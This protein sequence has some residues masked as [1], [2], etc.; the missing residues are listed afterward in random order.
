MCQE[1]T[2][3]GRDGP[4]AKKKCLHR[5]TSSQ[6]EILEGFFSLCAH[7][8]EKQRKKLTETTGLTDNQVKFWFQNKRTHVKHLSGKEENYQLKVENEI[9]RAENN[10]L[11]QAKRTIF[12]PRCPSEPGQLQIFQELQRLKSQNEW[13]QQEVSR[14]NSE[15]AMSSSSLSRAS[16]LEFSSENVFVMQDDAQIRAEIARNAVHELV[17]LASTDGPLWLP[18]PGGSMETLNRIA[19]I[20]AFPGQSSA[21]GLKVEATRAYAVVMLDSNNIVEYL[22]NAESYGTFFP[23]IMPGAT[24]TKVYNWPSSCDAGYDGAL[25]M[26]T[27]ELVFPSPLVPARKCTFLRYCQKLEHGATA[28]VDISV[29]NGEGNFNECRKM[30]SGILIEP[31]RTNTCK[32]TAIEHV[33]LEGPDVHDLFK[34]CLSGLLFGA[35]RWVT[36]MARQS[37]RMRDVYHVTNSSMIVSTKGRRIIMKMA[38]ALLANYAGSMAGIP[39]ES[40]IVQCGQGTEEDV[41]VMYRRHDNSANTAIVCASASFL[42][43]VPMRTALDLLKCNMLR[44]KWDVLVNGGNVKE[45]VRVANGI[46]TED[47]VSILHVKHGNKG[48]KETTMILQNSSYDASGSFLVYSALD[49][50]L[51]DM[52]MSPGS[53][54]EIGNV[55][56]FPTGFYLLPVP[57]ATRPDAA[58]GEGGGTVMTAGFQIL[59]KLARGTGLSSRSV[60]SAIRILS[61]QIESVKD[62]ML[63]SH[64]I[65]YKRALPTD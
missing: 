36:S 4:E 34:P 48:K 13:M 21:M 56:V 39:A 17:T 28:I 24:T 31:L 61:D 7:P 43:P 1:G 46:G 27:V 47:S 26:M 41:K 18:V 22:M 11:K 19:Y 65:F 50:Q 64:P 14:L 42:I 23:E 40:W 38:D 58:I 53:D 60:S 29:D 6:S 20:Q 32:V 54:Q 49:K 33:Q 5:L 52:I 37:A 15:L 51:L 25:E 62:T 57:D 55:P 12:C 3:D 30:A 44:V 10:K 63:N 45:E 35:R 9:L 59:M 16:Q 8:T 2:S